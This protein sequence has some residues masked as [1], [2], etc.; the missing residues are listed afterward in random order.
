[1]GLLARG[2][3]GRHLRKFMGVGENGSLAKRVMQVAGEVTLAVGGRLRFLSTWAS[4]RTAE[5]PH[6]V[7]APRRRVRGREPGRSHPVCDPALDFTQHHFP[8]L[9]L[10]RGSHS[11][12][13]CLREGD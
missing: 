6:D 5:C 10:F 4:P 11:P 13:L 7:G 12:G 8:H 3:L 2:H 9:L 1:M